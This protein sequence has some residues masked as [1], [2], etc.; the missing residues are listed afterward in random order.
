MA[1]QARPLSCICFHS[2]FALYT[3]DFC[4]WSLLP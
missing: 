4:F 3:D 1:A 2:T